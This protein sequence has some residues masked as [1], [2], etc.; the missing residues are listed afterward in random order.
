MATFPNN[1]RLFYNVLSSTATNLPQNN[2]ATTEKN[3]TELLHKW[4]HIHEN[5]LFIIFQNV[6]WFSNTPKPIRFGMESLGPME[7]VEVI[8]S[9]MT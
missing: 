8:I 7:F 2:I 6:R 5:I 9:L 3:I 4:H 1:K